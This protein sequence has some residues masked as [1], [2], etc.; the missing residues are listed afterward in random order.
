MQRF[1]PT[2]AVHM[3]YFSR[4]TSDWC[5]LRRAGECRAGGQGHWR[6]GERYKDTKLKESGVW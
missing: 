6:Q 5:L 1:T 4:L 2:H 3:L